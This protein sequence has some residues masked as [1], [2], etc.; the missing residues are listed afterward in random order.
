MDVVSTSNEVPREISVREERR[1]QESSLNWTWLL[2]VLLFVLAIVIILFLWKPHCFKSQEITQNPS[3]SIE[4]KKENSNL[5]K[6]TQ[7]SLTKEDLKKLKFGFQKGKA[8]LTPESL[9]TIDKISE[10]LQKESSIRLKIIGHSCDV[11]SKSFNQKISLA[12]ADLIKNLLVQKNI[13]PTRIVTEGK[14]EKEPISPNDTEENRA[15]NRRVEF[16]IIE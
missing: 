5:S 6:E 9:T 11:G 1:E 2:A 14:G 13:D 8:E 7:S 10:L 3:P 4:E 12:R 15:K 16:Q